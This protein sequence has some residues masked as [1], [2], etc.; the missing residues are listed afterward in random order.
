MEGWERLCIIS[1][2]HDVR[3]VI[4]YEGTPLIPFSNKPLFLT[5]PRSLFFSPVEFC[6]RRNKE[7]QVWT[8]AEDRILLEKDPDLMQQLK[9]ERGEAAVRDRLSFLES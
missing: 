7:D 2:T 4:R 6:S 1:K 8:L 9:A 3:R 5:I